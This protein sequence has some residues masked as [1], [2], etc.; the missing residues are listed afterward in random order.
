MNKSSKLNLICMGLI[1]IGTGTTWMHH[2]N[3][4]PHQGGQVPKLK[5]SQKGCFGKGRGSGKAWVSMEG[6]GTGG[7]GGG[8]SQGANE[9]EK[10]STGRF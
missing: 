10:E 4:S 7:R 3:P 6:G 2:H 8:G 5:H 1:G 9:K